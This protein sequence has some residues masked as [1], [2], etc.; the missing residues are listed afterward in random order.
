MEESRLQ[1]KTLYCSFV[2]FKKA[3]DT[4]PL[5]ELWNRMVEIDMPLKYRVV[6]ARLYE[7]LNAN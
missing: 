7:K 3:F 4:A 6:V 1:G 2:D 5:S